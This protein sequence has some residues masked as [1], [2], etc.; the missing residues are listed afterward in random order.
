MR[1]PFYSGT[2]RADSGFFSASVGETS[3]IKNS[4]INRFAVWWPMDVEVCS[5]LLAAFALSTIL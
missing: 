1:E 4:P 5:Q 2:Q 3:S